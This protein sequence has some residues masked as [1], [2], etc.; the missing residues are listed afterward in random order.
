MIHPSRRFAIA[1][2][3]P[4]EHEEFIASVADSLAQSLGRERIFYYKW[5]EHELAGTE[6]DLKLLRCY[7]EQSDLVVPFFS[8]HYRKHWCRVEW[9]AIR[10]MLLERRSEDAVVPVQ[11]D[12]TDIDGWERVDFTIPRENRTAREIAD[13]LVKAYQHRYPPTGARA[14]PSSLMDTIEPNWHLKLD[15]IEQTGVATHLVREKLHRGRPKCVAFC[16]YGGERD[17]VDTFHDRLTDEFQ[18]VAERRSWE[19]RPAWPPIVNRKGFEEMLRL[20][21]DVKSLTDLGAMIRR[22]FDGTQRQVLYVNHTPI[23][24]PKQL[25]PA[26]LLEYLRWWDEAVLDH[27]ESNQHVVLGIS[28]IVKNHVNFRD[29]IDRTISTYAFGDR[30][31]FEALSVL[32]PLKAEHLR[33]FFRRI[34][35]QFWL[36][37]A[38]QEQV[39]ATIIQKTNGE[40]E[41]VVRELERLFVEGFRE[42]QGQATT[43]AIVDGTDDEY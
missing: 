39:I 14:R 16:W 33:T 19:V 20:T 1:L 3:F 12:D 22:H 40:Y 37:R 41:L 25:N 4:S 24:S 30:F 15:R 17:G 18:Q 8:E 29:R 43:T 36:D 32:Q 42:F 38:R 11:F 26:Q 27:V 34:S 6:G 31:L 21:L 13:V 2:S 23:T 10:A 5:Y 35:I 28:F 7:R 9:N